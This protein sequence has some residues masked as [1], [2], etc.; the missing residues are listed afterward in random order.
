MA[1]IK[2]GKNVEKQ[3]KNYII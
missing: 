3:N 2:V 1:I